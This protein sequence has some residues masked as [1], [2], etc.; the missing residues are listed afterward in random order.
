MGAGSVLYPHYLTNLRTWGPTALDDQS[1]GGILM[2]VGG[3]VAFLVGMAC[4]VAMWV[5]AE[6]R[7][8]ARLDAR[9][10]AESR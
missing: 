6:D 5:R 7:R 10:D 2:W 3:D 4:V 9:L 1:L 8:T